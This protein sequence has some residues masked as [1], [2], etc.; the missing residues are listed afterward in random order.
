MANDDRDLPVVQTDLDEEAAP[1]CSPTI[2]VS[3]EEA[4]LLAAMRNLR[5]RSVEL[6]KELRDTDPQQRSRLES[7]INEMRAKWKDLAAQREKAFVRKMVMLG[8]LPAEADI[9]SR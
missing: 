6:K 8:H 5:N 4:A 7:E 9:E 2:Y 3:N 1:S